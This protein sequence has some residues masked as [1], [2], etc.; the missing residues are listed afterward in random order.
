MAETKTHA[1]FFLLL[2]ALATVLGFIILHPYFT[3]VIVG[4]ILAV[5]F[6]PLYKRFL[7]RVRT[8]TLA[9]AATLAL[10]LIIVLIP[11]LGIGVQVVNEAGDVYARLTANGTLGDIIESLE[12]TI[13]KYI[14]GA[15]IQISDAQIREYARQAVGKIIENIGPV[16]S[17]VAGLVLR[18]VLTLMALFYFLKDGDKF[19]EKCIELSPLAEKDN[20]AIIEKIRVAIVS[21][22]RGSLV[23]GV[24]QGMLTGIGFALFG[25]P[26]PALWG[27]LAA[28]AALVPGVGTS[29][30]NIPGILFL[31]I[32][33]NYLNALL[34]LVWAAG[35]VGLVDN[36]LGPHLI[37]KRT[38]IHQFL[39]LLSVLGGIK[40]FGPVGFLIGPLVLSF[41]L[42]L[43][44]MY[45][46]IILKRN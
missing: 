14:P 24:V 45:P 26:N 6:Y 27:S 1:N 11:L 5:I 22:I 16:F 31:V 21:V 15:A 20:R 37:S 41:L 46:S 32:S 38:K 3:S 36:L 23:I 18:I 19:R 40:A 30:I 10:V 35:A 44:D 43:L 25:V 34:L 28:I 17:G 7:S 12:R 13:A 4:G 9:A 8:K 42:A 33:G 29:L 2:L 39:I